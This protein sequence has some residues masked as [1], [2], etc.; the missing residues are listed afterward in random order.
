MRKISITVVLVLALTRTPAQAQDSNADRLVVN[1]SDSSRPGLLKVNW[2]SGGIHVRTHS[3]KEVIIHS[4]A[5]DNRGRRGPTQRLNSPM[6]VEENDNVI[7][8]TRGPGPPV[9]LDIEVPIK[10]NL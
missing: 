6:N 10:T 4:Q 5:T 8:V 7:V 1:F 3:G 2:E 9:D